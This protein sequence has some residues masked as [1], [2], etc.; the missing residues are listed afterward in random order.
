[1]SLVTVFGREWLQKNNV[2]MI[3]RMVAIAVSEIGRGSSSFDV[4][5]QEYLHAW[6][7]EGFVSLVESG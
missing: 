1:M 3:G 2:T 5:N 7:N 4:R 6:V